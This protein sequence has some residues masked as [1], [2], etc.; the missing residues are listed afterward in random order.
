MRL[1]HI[2]ACAIGLALASG[3]SGC[4]EYLA[5]RDTLLLESGEAVQANIAIQ[6]IDP[7]PPSAARINRDIDGER[8]QHAIARYRNPQST[9]GGGFGSPGPVPIGAPVAPPLGSQLNR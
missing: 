3:V 7:M 2:V 1:P 4:T 8:L 9:Q 6:V 5:R